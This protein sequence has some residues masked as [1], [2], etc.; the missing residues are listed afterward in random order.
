MK[1]KIFVLDFLRLKHFEVVS[2]ALVFG[3]SGDV[4][5]FSN[6]AQLFHLKKYRSFKFN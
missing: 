4:R 1:L 2:T 6:F 5:N 3:T